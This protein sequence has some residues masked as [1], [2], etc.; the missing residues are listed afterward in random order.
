MMG[1]GDWLFTVLLG[2][3]VMGL[4]MEFYSVLGL[5]KSYW[6]RMRFIVGWVVMF[7]SLTGLFLLW[8]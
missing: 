8:R 5:I 7:G 1:L 4:T 3:G 2:L 6:P